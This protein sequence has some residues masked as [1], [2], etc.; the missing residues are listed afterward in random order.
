[1]I[2]LVGDFRDLLVGSSI[3]MTFGQYLKEVSLGGLLSIVV[4]VPLL[5][6]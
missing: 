1:M 5:R 6:C 4:I 3:G 2:T